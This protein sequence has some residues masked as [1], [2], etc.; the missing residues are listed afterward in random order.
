MRY[1]ALI[2]S[3]LY[4][5]LTFAADA[6]QARD[7]RLLVE[8][9]AEHPQI[10]TPTGLA[11]A[12]DGRVFV[13]E[14]HTHF[15]PDDYDGPTFDRILIFEDTDG[16]GRADKRKIFHEG[17]IHVMDIEFCH[18]GS[19][20]VATRRDIHRMRD[21][22][23]DDQADEVTRI[24]WLETE[25][26]YPHNGLS[27]LAFDFDGGLNFGLGENLG[28]PYTLHGSDG[29]S[30]SGGGEG[31]STYHVQPD[32]TKLR[33]ISTGWWNPYGM[34]VD[35]FGRVFGTDNDPGSSPPCRLIQVIEG[36]NYGYEYRYG[37][38]GL[39]PLVGWNGEIPG[40]LPMVA[41]TGEAPC[42]I[43]AYESN[44]FPKEYLGNLFVSCWADHRVERFTISQR[45][46]KGLVHAQ[47]DILIDGPDDFRPVGIDVA[48]DGSV[49]IS[50]WVSSSYSLHKQGRLWRI[51][52]QVTPAQANDSG[53]VVST[54]ASHSIPVPDLNELTDLLETHGDPL[55]I[56]AG[57]ANLSEQLTRSSVSMA[58]TKHSLAILLAAR[59]NKLLNQYLADEKLEHF[60]AAKNPDTRFVA[61]KWIADDLLVDY[62]PILER[63]LNSSDLDFRLFRAVAA[64]IDRLDGNEP[65]DQPSEQLLLSKITDPDAPIAIR[66]LCLRMI[67]P[68][69]K[70]LKLDDLIKLTR[71]A[72]VELRLEAVRTLANHPDTSRNNTLSELAA[73]EQQSKEVRAA[74]IAALA[75]SAESHIDLLLGIARADNPGLRYEALRALV[76]LELS[77]AQRL[78]VFA[79]SP[80]DP[81]INE[82]VNRI[83]NGTTGERP[84]AHQTAA[85]KQLL[86]SHGDVDAGQRIFFGAKVGTCS[87]CHTM[88]GRGSAVGPDLSKIRQR[89][90]SE[91]VEWLLETI[92]QPSKQM[93]PQYTPWQ[94]VTTDG[95]TLVGLPRRKG[96]NQE[97]YLG[98]DGKEF[99][100][101]K[102][103]IEFHREMS[104]SIMPE[105]L[106]QNLTKQ[107][108]NDLFA[109][110]LGRQ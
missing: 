70:G 90:A 23:G 26:N 24:V 91:G 81:A 42:A 19:L 46:D 105:G 89:I 53:S 87:R 61:V 80:V 56:H 92:L 77:D 69:A 47:R 18:D 83:L 38:T 48:P 36:G 2:C 59:R 107:E 30:F 37:R 10:M 98:M 110:I 82:A 78:Q 99:S 27:G 76:G 41:G 1:S 8:L 40:T 95:K 49:F 66:S 102:P 15:R 20:Y 45:N 103:D 17:F 60:L 57:I 86:T 14:S 13:A 22:D 50:D 21:T 72:D 104:T 93:A 34:C 68:D 6:P 94:I 101:K 7:E 54:Q 51:R 11:V 52:P 63:M 25:G 108:L 55:A 16:D 73:D 85:W 74:A 31:G 12:D 67:A 84:N 32:G 28:A 58:D 75:P 96:G 79:S 65:S 109:F 3:L 29:T 39:H 33:R 62:R 35:A 43:V 71:H 44:A 64:A 9:F 88:D 5:S 4:G 106:L 97:A 100:V